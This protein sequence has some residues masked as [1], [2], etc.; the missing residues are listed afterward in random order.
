MGITKLMHIKERD[1]GLSSKG[2]ENSINYIMNP[3]KTDNKSLVF[4]NCGL[5]EQQIYNSFLDT[6][7]NYNKQ[8]GRQGYHFVI[9]FSPDENVSEG[10][11]MNIMND[12]VAKYLNNE[13]DYVVAV[14]NDTNH[15]H[16]HLIFNS[17]NSVTGLKYRYEKGDWEKFIQPITDSIAQRY[18]LKKLE[19][20]SFEEE[21]K[22]IIWGDIIKNN[23]DECIS[24]SDSYEQFIELMSEKFHYQIREGTSNMHGVYLSLKPEGKSK[25]IRSY[26]LPIDYQPEYIKYRIEGNF[27]PLKSPVVNN[28][29]QKLAYKVFSKKKYIKW[30]DMT[31]YQKYKFKKMMKARAIYGSRSNRPTWEQKRIANLIN[32]QTKEYLFLLNNNLSIEN[33]NNYINDI[34]KKLS[35]IKKEINSIDMKYKKYIYGK[36]SIFSDFEK[37]I[38]IRDKKSKTELEKIFINSFTTE[39][40]VDYV[41]T[42]YNNY[43]SKINP[44]KKE[45]LEL[46]KNRKVANAIINNNKKATKSHK[47]PQEKAK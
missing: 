2:L 45:K 46:Y 3:D 15:M 9:S 5:T 27:L 26:H 1:K 19:F 34:N 23:I 21:S 41:N 39:Y 40:D 44:I 43:Y 4:S 18:G 29:N 10:E 38:S 20:T 25:A 8:D 35:M 36:P 30:K 11:C 32:R 28:N 13:Y 12:F 22:G 47:K 24:I 14:H 6:K 31:A 37:F 33:I 7:R 42:L 16:G 17:V